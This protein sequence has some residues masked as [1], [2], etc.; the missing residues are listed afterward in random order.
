MKKIVIAFLTAVNLLSI[1]AVKAQAQNATVGNNTAVETAG[2]NVIP[3]I[4][5]LV[6]PN[7]IETRCQPFRALNPILE[8]DER[9]VNTR[10]WGTG[11]QSCKGEI[12]WSWNDGKGFFDW[13]FY[14]SNLPLQITNVEKLS[15]SITQTIK[16]SHSLRKDA[17][18]VVNSAQEFLQAGA[19]ASKGRDTVKERSMSE[20]KT[21]ESS[22]QTNITILF[23]R[24]LGMAL[25]NV[26]PAKYNFCLSSAVD[27]F[28]RAFNTNRVNDFVEAFIFF[29]TIKPED[30][31]FTNE[32]DFLNRA[33][34]LYLISLTDAKNS[35]E[36]QQFGWAGAL[37]F[38]KLLEW[39][40]FQE[41]RK[42]V[43]DYLDK[44]YKEYQLLKTHTTKELLQI[45]K[46][47]ALLKFAVDYNLRNANKTQET[48]EWYGHIATFKFFE[49][50]AKQAWEQ[51]VAPELQK[52]LDEA[53][54]KNDPILEAK[55]IKD[56]E[57]LKVANFVKEK[58]VVA[59]AVGVGAGAVGVGVVGALY[60]RK[61]KQ[62][63]PEEKQNST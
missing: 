2:N 7:F 56:K 10:A 57:E 16:S 50:K 61:R 3:G 6:L 59:G 37:L 26:F 42:L 11:A 24:F 12:C 9:Y 63:P 15:K 4:N 1:P 19:G 5:Y 44:V 14:T 31:Q 49:P 58:P 32:K 51:Q 41:V 55:F 23:H 30:L 60:L 22:V 29:Q 54:K 52:Q 40:E 20:T 33:K 27:L 28:Y 47:L 46:N 62:N 36:Q 35:K 21:Q 53:L 8:L 38:A 45:D 48:D 25:Q 43:D 13:Q 39:E 17:N 18:S 34:F